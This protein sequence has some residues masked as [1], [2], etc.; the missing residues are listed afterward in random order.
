VYC[1]KSHPWLTFIAYERGKCDLTKHYGLS[2]EQARYLVVCVPFGV[3]PS[4][5]CR[6]T[7]RAMINT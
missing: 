4:V 5:G 1:E 3:A 2:K 7:I 6:A